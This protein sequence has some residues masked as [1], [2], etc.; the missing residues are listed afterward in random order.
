MDAFKMYLGN[1]SKALGDGWMWGWGKW[2]CQG[3]LPGSQQE[4]M[5]DGCSVS[6]MKNFGERSAVCV[7]LHV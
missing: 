7:C 2:A 1:R 6:D 5:V 4:Q 3:R